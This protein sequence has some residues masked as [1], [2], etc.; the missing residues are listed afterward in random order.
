MKI[1][2]CGPEKW[3]A[4]PFGCATKAWCYLFAIKVFH[5]WSSPLASGRVPFPTLKL[6]FLDMFR[7]VDSFEL[8]FVSLQN[9]VYVLSNPAISKVIFLFQVF[10]L[11]FG[12]PLLKYVCL[13]MRTLWLLLMNALG[14]PVFTL[15]K[16]K[17]RVL[18]CLISFIMSKLCI[19]PTSRSY[20]LTIRR[21][22][23]KK[24]MNLSAWIIYRSSNFLLLYTLT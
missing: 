13:D 6:V 4:I 11:I 17:M 1:L 7:S 10:I 21:I 16:I 9:I 20:V 14:W 19:M 22:Y 2:G 3:R 5:K 15:L 24:N 23:F 12:G 8:K 18:A